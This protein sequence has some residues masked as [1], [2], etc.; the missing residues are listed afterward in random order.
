M[1]RTLSLLRHAKAANTGPR[2]D[3]HS[4]PLNERG[5]QAA[6]RM[7]KEAASLS[8][9]PNH[10]YCSD[11]ARTKETCGIFLQ[12]IGQDI[13]VSD[14]N[15]LYLASQGDLLDFINTLIPDDIEHALLIGHN[16]GFHLLAM[17]LTGHGDGELRTQ[18]DEKFPTATLT[19]LIFPT[20]H[21]RYVT[22]QRG[23]VTHY[24]RPA[25]LGCG[26]D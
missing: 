26:E 20:E 6:L 24:I 15:N 5:Q 1:T 16:P 8:I 7:G 17:T 13:P 3:D 23:T 18:L 9:I 19:T 4:R 2:D 22:P 21:W 14:H 25:F 11:S 10:V 12:G